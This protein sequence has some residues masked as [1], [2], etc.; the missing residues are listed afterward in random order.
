MKHLKLVS[1]VL[2][3]SQFLLGVDGILEHMHLLFRTEMGCHVNKRLIESN[4][5]LPVEDKAA[6]SP[7]P[8]AI[9]NPHR[10]DVGKE[11]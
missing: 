8:K 1:L 11:S 2:D 5:L 9:S 6:G 7:I 3:L 4:L 10:S